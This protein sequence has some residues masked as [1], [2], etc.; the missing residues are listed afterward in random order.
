MTIGKDL[1]QRNIIRAAVMGLMMVFIRIRYC[2]RCCG[3]T[4]NS[5]QFCAGFASAL[6]GTVSMAMGEYVSVH[7][8]MMR[9]SRP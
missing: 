9:K 2:Y 1:A 5:L 4:T 3:A 6:A 7:S 8:K